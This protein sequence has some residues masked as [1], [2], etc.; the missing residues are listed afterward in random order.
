MT[1]SMS[2]PGKTTI[3]PDVLTTI[4]RLTT[5]SVEGVSR[6]CPEPIGVSR[7]FHKGLKDGVRIEV[8]DDK[9]YADLYVVLNDDVNIRDVSRNIQMKVARAISDMVGMQVGQ[10]N[11]HIEDIDYPGDIEA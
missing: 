8:E 11:I 5:L 3:A 9:V 7:L 4:A 2:T 6:F 1:G 10:V